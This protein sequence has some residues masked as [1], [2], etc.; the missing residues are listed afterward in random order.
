MAVVVADVSLGAWDAVGRPLSVPNGNEAI[1]L[2]VQA[3]GADARTISSQDR[4]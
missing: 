2:T 3:A 4:E 1:M